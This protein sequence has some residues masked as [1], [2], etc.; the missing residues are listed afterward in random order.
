MKRRPPRPHRWWVLPAAACAALLLAAAGWVLGNGLRVL[1]AEDQAPDRAAPGRG[2]W[3]PA[4]DVKLHLT[5]QGAAAAPVLVLV[6]GAGAWAGTWAGNAEALQAAGWRV[7][8]VDLPPF[9]F[10]TRPADANYSRHAQAQRLLAAIRSLH[11]APVVLLGHAYGGGAAAEA[12]MLDPT[13]IRHLIL[14]DA[15]I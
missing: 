8:S 13:L 4:Q 15:T 7:V 10:S 9:G 14:V 6:A 12:A 2:R 3:V 1:A 5:D 11:A